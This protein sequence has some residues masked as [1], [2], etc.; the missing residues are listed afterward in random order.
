[1][2]DYN[3]DDRSVV[4]ELSTAFS[5]AVDVNGGDRDYDYDGFA[6]REVSE[7]ACR[8]CGLSDPA[9]VVKSVNADKW[10]CNGRGMSIP[11]F[12]VYFMLYQSTFILTPNNALVSLTYNILVS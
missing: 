10:F 4:S 3:D 7:Y 12:Y 6:D 8:Y 2:A 9:C 5:Q 1:M 11:V